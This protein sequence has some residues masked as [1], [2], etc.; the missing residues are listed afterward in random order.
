MK[1]EKI[2]ELGCL[3]DTN[4]ERE[5]IGEFECLRNVDGKYEMV[6]KPAPGAPKLT[7]EQ[8]EVNK[9]ICEGFT[10]LANSYN[11]NLDKAMDAIISKLEAEE[12]ELRDQAS[13]LKAE[14]PK[15]E[16]LKPENKVEVD[17]AADAE[18]EVEA[19]A[20]EDE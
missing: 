8:K 12:Q 6:Y 10:I 18:I 2:G 19:E 14:L 7:E 17:T 9:A 16:P 13:Q 1:K 11:G 5:K 4:G 3:L 20:S 15:S